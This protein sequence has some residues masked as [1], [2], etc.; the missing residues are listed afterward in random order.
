[1]PII[2]G[3]NMSNHINNGVDYYNILQYIKT[4]KN[5]ENILPTSVGINQN[6]CLSDRSDLASLSSGD[7]VVGEGNSPEETS[8]LLDQTRVKKAIIQLFCNENSS[9]KYKLK[10]QLHLIDSPK[11]VEFIANLTTDFRNFR[12]FIPEPGR[13]EILELANLCRS[14]IKN[15][16]QIRPYLGKFHLNQG[17]H[18]GQIHNQIEP[19][20]FVAIW[21]NKEF[22]YWSGILKI[23]DFNLKFDL[24]QEYLSERQQKIGIKGYYYF[25]N[26]LY[27]SQHRPLTW[28]EQQGRKK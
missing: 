20:T 15:E 28:A 16:F 23:I 21:F 4:K 9:Q 19:N 8:S 10:I 12:K 26:P 2:K 3:V 6:I 18:N 22:K 25:Q 17:W 5:K 14:K 24:I 27:Q 11:P 7:Q 13:D 1:M